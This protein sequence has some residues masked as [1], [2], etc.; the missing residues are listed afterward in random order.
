MGNTPISIYL[1]IYLIINGLIKF[2][3]KN[4][5]Y[6]NWDPKNF[7][8]VSK[9]YVKSN[10]IWVPDI[11][12]MDS[13]DEKTTQRDSFLL[14][15]ESDGLVS[16]HFQTVITNFCKINIMN[17]PFDDQLCTIN[18]RSSGFDKSQIR[19]MKRNEKVQ[20]NFFLTESFFFYYNKKRSSNLSNYDFIYFSQNVEKING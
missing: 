17:F 19:L 7:A 9:L 1:S 20:L 10:E 14:I 2:S 5:S 6:L 3:L 4:D 11:I 12:L 18:I 8:N 16:W 13:L 15:V